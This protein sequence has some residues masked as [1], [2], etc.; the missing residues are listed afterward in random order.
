MTEVELKK[1]GWTYQGEDKDYGI[2]KK[3]W[4]TKR[5]PLNR[6]RTHKGLPPNP[7]K[8][9]A[10]VNLK[11]R[12]IE[13]PPKH[14]KVK[15][16]DCQKFYQEVDHYSSLIEETINFVTSNYSKLL[17]EISENNHEFI[18]EFSNGFNNSVGR[19]VG[20]HN[21]L[22]SK[23]NN[24]LT[25]RLDF[26]NSHSGKE[27]PLVGCLALT[28]E[29]LN[30]YKRVMNSYYTFNDLIKIYFSEITS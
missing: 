16:T 26:I 11:I 3:G 6:S 29:M 30:K 18:D 17:E 5:V 19:I 24:L 28:M 23:Y 10:P 7:K 4:T 9:E 27:T 13:T 12:V 20:Y 21:S 15:L 25:K 2:W 22:G 14:P 8:A 1:N